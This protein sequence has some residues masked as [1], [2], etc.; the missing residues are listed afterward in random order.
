MG[1][2]SMLDLTAD[3]THLLVGETTTPKYR[4][5]AK[6]RPDIKPLLPSFISAVRERWLTGEDV[7]VA[8]LEK[9]HACP[10]F[11]G[12]KVCITGFDTL[13]ERKNVKDA[14]SAHGGTYHGDLTKDV[15]H[16]VVARCEGAKYKFAK[17]W[18]IHRVSYK[19]IADSLQRG[20]ALDEELYAP[21]LPL[22]QQGVGAF[23][24]LR[25]KTRLGKRKS[26]G[27][28]DGTDEGGKRKV[29]KVASA[30]LENHSQELWHSI[31]THE[32]Q[33]ENTELH[34]W[35]DDSQ[36][37]G[38]D[39][40]HTAKSRGAGD[41]QTDTTKIGAADEPRGLFAGFY[42]L[43][44]GF[45]RSRA[46]RLGDFLIPNGASLVESLDE[47]E[48]ASENAFFRERCLLVP[49]AKP[50]SHTELPDAPPT[51]LL[52]SEWWVE[53]CIHY[54]QFMDPSDDPLSRP[55]WDISGA[56]LADLT[57]GTTGFNSVDLRQ[58]AQAVRALG[59]SYQEKIL[60]SM[61]VLVAASD[62]VR[63]EKALYASKHKIP[64]VSQ[65]WLWETLKTKSKVSL[66][67]YR[68]SLPAFNPAELARDPS[69][70]SP[71]P[72]EVFR[73]PSEP[74]KR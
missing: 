4:Y 55:L 34:A 31:S 45:D 54:K 70:S 28:G 16:L 52:V 39:E 41:E 2:V 7:D 58:T 30:R 11:L 51:T 27:E 66:D 15:T 50:D 62:T 72:S 43:V 23:K 57:I 5:T 44:H 13:E 35:D 71:A 19:W 59:A 47:L 6:E 1:A 18:G 26:E 9:A 3:V 65:R 37:L 12:R 36:T 68:L 49:H 40:G 56:E 53:R 73:H 61:S 69:T 21:E 63:R 33:V 67:S 46:K 17:Q 25:E 24:T 64:V 29:R 22:E 14:V 48:A 42:I 20:M 32:V 74:A 60:P 8:A 38:R 10:P